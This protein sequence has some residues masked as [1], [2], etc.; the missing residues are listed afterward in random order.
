MAKFALRGVHF[1]CALII[2]AMLSTSFAIFNATKHLPSQSKMPA[3]AL[4]TNP[5]PQ[6]LVLGLACV[7]LGISILVF[8]AYCRGGHKRAEKV[9]TYYNMFAIGWVSCLDLFL[10]S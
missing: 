2:L 9:N 6:K 3:W 4:G 10:V 5:W 7:S 8:F 1:S